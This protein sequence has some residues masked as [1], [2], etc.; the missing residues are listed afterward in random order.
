MGGRSV[1]RLAIILVLVL[2]FAAAWTGCGK[3]GDPLPPDMVLPVAAHDLRVLRQ[4][5]GVRISWVLPEK[6]RNL[7]RVVIQRSEFET[8]LDRCPECP[9][10]YRILAD[11]QLGD[12]RLDRTGGREMAYMDMDVR[13]GRLYMYRIL[14]CNSGGA[15]SDASLPAEI[16][17]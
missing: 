3:K 10:E 6:E 1:D 13:S 12:P 2:L 4:A 16:K 5:E 7:H 14:V 9:Q 17:F 11:L 15:C 8:M